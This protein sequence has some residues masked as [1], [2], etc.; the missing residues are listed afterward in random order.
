MTSLLC[1]HT[2]SK[3]THTHTRNRTH[4]YL[5]TQMCPGTFAHTC[6]V[7]VYTDTHT[8]QVWITARQESTEILVLPDGACNVCV[9]TALVFLIYDVALRVCLLVC[10][11]LCICVGDKS[12]LVFSVFFCFFSTSVAIGLL[13]KP[14][15]QDLVYHQP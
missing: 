10:L 7:G 2:H 8:L 15:A 3:H 5:Y 4:N 13:S 14:Q 1:I 11:S 6:T 9:I 12:C